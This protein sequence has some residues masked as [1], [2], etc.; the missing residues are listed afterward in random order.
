MKK[1]IQFTHARRAMG[2]ALMLGLLLGAGWAGA[3]TATTLA[4]TAATTASAPWG[5]E[6]FA[7][8][9]PLWPPRRFFSFK[10]GN[11]GLSIKRD[12]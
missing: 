7:P 8:R 3:Q 12:S 11:W 1:H 4:E 9:P 10:R 6:F 5:G 2:V